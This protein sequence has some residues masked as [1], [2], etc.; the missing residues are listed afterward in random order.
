MTP[1]SKRDAMSQPDRVAVTH[2]MMPQEKVWRRKNAPHFYPTP[3][4]TQ[5]RSSRLLLPKTLG[6]WV[7]V[8]AIIVAVLVVL[9]GSLVALRVFSQTGC[10]NFG[11]LRDTL[12]VAGASVTVKPSDLSGDFGARL[13]LLQQDSAD[14]A[15]RRA[16][17]ELPPTIEQRSAWVVA[18]H[19]CG[20]LPRKAT[21]RVALPEGMNARNL[22]LYG[23]FTESENWQWLGGEIDRARNELVAQVRQMPSFMVVAAPEAAPQW[24]SVE[25]P[26]NVPFAQWS[27]ALP[28]SAQEVVVPV[29]YLGDVIN[30]LSRRR[31]GDMPPPRLSDGRAVIPL[32]RNWSERGQVNAR[33]LRDIL[34]DPEARARHAADLIRLLDITGYDGVELDYRGLDETMQEPFAQFVERL[35]RSL[36]QRGKRL[37][38]VV[39]APQ[40]ALDGSWT[41]SGYDWEVITRVADRVK[42]DLTANLSA[43]ADAEQLDS[44][45][46]WATARVDRYKLV[47]LLPAASLLQDTRNHV[48]PMS[49]EDALR[50]LSPVR[51]QPTVAQPLS[52][53]WLQW[54][55]GVAADGV[56]LGAATHIYTFT[57]VSE[58]GEPYT[59]WLNTAASIRQ[60]LSR[61]QAHVLRGVAVRWLW[62]IGNDKGIADVIDAYTR[63]QLDSINLPLPTAKVAFDNSTPFSFS[64]AE[65]LLEVYAPGG[66]GE[67][68]LFVFFHANRRISI[69][70]VPFTVSVNASPSAPP[71]LPD[72]S[73]SSQN[74]GH[75][76]H[77]VEQFELGGHVFNLKRY[78]A[79]MRAAGMRWVR[80]YWHDSVPYPLKTLQDARAKGFKV[81]ITAVGDR[82]RVLD[83]DY[84][85]A[86]SQR[87]AQLA[88]AGADAIEVWSEPNYKENW[89]TGSINGADYTDLLKRAYQAIKQARP[90][91]LVISAALMQ[92][93]GAYFGGCT[94][95]GCDEL[96]FLSQM[97]AAGAP[98]YMDCIGVHYTVGNTPPDVTGQA[99]FTRYLQ[100]LQNAIL[101]AF[102]N[103]KPLCFTALG[104]LSP[105]GF[106]RP[107][108]PEYGF[109][110]N[111]TLAQQTQWLARAVHMLAVS[112]STRLAII[113]NLDST[114]WVSG[115]QGDP[116][117][118]YAMVRP[119][120]TCPS[121]EAIRAVM[122][123]LP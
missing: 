60:V 11:F 114:K 117:A 77:L 79:H 104:Y 107:L 92:T 69:D 16:M 121:C 64:L 10:E 123:S 27:A 47:V 76:R 63:G 68:T 52:S 67:Y 81:L 112:G 12:A 84:R 55:P 111:N 6:Q 15:L 18:V 100:P 36:S 87:L 42:L 73:P 99:H 59:V 80:L 44:L 23:W 48:R 31:T 109:A 33:L 113:W 71:P 29:A 34:R 85:D 3:H 108:P 101:G 74:P 70:A 102:N 32:V 58:T 78:E 41:L 65:P 5:T 82:T 24:I 2:H 106:N 54:S 46:E 120:G 90:E 4:G 37:V 98:Q 45:L 116:Q 43:M 91:V 118:G 97:A 89:P 86:W 105:E 110:V 115:E 122:G 50:P 119:D 103:K 57:H 56:H 13:E 8:I 53:V 75:R 25:A 39:P 72:M 93:T 14:A 19:T 21:L 35:G 38:I 51:V 20:A 7:Q 83:P 94:S 40:R 1:A 61:L 95:E 49:L 88:L 28:A 9:V 62:Q 26:E 66:N 17:E 22:D 30:T 96:E